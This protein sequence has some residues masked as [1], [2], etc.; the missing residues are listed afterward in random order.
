[1]KKENEKK[2]TKNLTNLKLNNFL[3]EQIQNLNKFKLNDKTIF[4]EETKY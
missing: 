2:E 4:F 1:M 3:F